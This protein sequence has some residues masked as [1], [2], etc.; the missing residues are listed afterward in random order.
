MG[1]ATHS[2]PGVRV[3]W[4]WSRA[5]VPTTHSPPW[6]GSAH[7]RIGFVAL[8]LDFF[9]PRWLL[10]PWYLLTGLCYT[11]GAKGRWNGPSVP[12]TI[13][14]YTPPP[15]LSPYNISAV[16]DSYW[17][18]FLIYFISVP[19]ISAVTSL[20]QASQSGVRKYLRS[21]TGLSCSN[22]TLSALDFSTLATRVIFGKQIWP[23]HSSA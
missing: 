13:F 2:S 3:R 5:T 21:L 14:D 6:L 19:P 11:S 9:W 4:P 22:V 12:T 16:I 1:T 10:L 15:F 17:F 23:W 20:I 18:Y 7:W 8:F